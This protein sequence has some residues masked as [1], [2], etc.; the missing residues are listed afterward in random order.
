MHVA[1]SFILKEDIIMKTGI[2]LRFGED[3][4]SNLVK[5]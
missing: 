4:D 5:E 3:G 2:Q 1:T